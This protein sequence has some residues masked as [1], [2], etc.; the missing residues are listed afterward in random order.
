MLAEKN[1]F[2]LSNTKIDFRQKRSVSAAIEAMFWTWTKFSNPW[3][4]GIARTRKS[5]WLLY[6]ISNERIMFEWKK[7]KTI[8]SKPVD[9]ANGHQNSI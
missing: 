2:D 6:A 7:T 9:K 3:D 5:L 4:G 8:E 1:V